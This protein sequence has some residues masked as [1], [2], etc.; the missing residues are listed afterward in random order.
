MTKQKS[1]LGTICAKN[2]IIIGLCYLAAYFLVYG[3]IILRFGLNQDEILDFRG[4][5]SD[6]YLAAGRWGIVLYK[7][8]F[9]SGCSPYIAGIVSGIYLAIAFVVQTRLL[10][11][12]S[13]GSSLEQ[14]AS[15]PLSMHRCW[16]TAFR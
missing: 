6:S 13:L 14:S 15:A 11:L 12:K 3:Y 10:R 2:D 5:A 7:D 4:E 16:S 1:P 9:V 8:F